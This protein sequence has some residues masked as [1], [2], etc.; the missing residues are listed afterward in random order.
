LRRERVARLPGFVEPIDRRRGGDG[1]CS[2]SSSSIFSFLERGRDVELRGLDEL[3]RLS[4]RNGLSFT[5]SAAAALLPLAHD[6]EPR[7][8]SSSAAAAAALDRDGNRRRPGLQVAA[9]QFHRGAVQRHGLGDV[10]EGHHG[11]EAGDERRRRRRARRARNHRQRHALD[12]L[13]CR[14]AL[15]AREA[16]RREEP[17][18]PRGA[19]VVGNPDA[20][21]LA[22][23]GEGGV[24][25]SRR[26]GGGGGGGFAA[27]AVAS[28]RREQRHRRSLSSSRLP[29]RRLG[30]AQPNREFRGRRRDR[31]A[32]WPMPIRLRDAI[33]A[34]R[35]EE[36]GVGHFSSRSKSFSRPQEEGQK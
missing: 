6:D 1:S 24:G 20:L 25:G 5:S 34:P 2:S 35:A 19:D 4:E 7:R 31:I 8:R 3:V 22:G 11:E 13:L 29:L 28:C 16:H 33:T 9:G 21:E 27:V 18:A 26:G 17:G 14:H 36:L 30:G 15:Q 12:E 32:S 10:E 23:E